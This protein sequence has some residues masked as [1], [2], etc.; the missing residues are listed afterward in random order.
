[1]RKI[2]KRETER[3]EIITELI[4]EYP[5]KKHA[6]RTSLWNAVRWNRN[7]KQETG[8]QASQSR[9]FWIISTFIPTRICR[10]PRA[11]NTDDIQYA[12]TPLATLRNTA[13]SMRAVEHRVSVATKP[14]PRRFKSACVLLPAAYSGGAISCLWR[15]SKGTAWYEYT[16]AKREKPKSWHIAGKQSA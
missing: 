8:E 12:T 3:K 11:P 1:M 9:C 10:K 4:S 5:R 7:Q 2:N 15:F 13:T 16:T 14:K 6:K